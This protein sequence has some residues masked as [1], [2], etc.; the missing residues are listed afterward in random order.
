MV[1][2]SSST[3]SQTT[4]MYLPVAVHPKVEGRPVESLGTVRFFKLLTTSQNFVLRDP[5][6]DNDVDI[7]AIRVVFQVPYDQRLEWNSQEALQLLSIQRRSELDL[8]YNESGRRGKP[9]RTN[10][11]SPQKNRRSRSSKPR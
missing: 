10:S 7:V 6:F 8:Y 1:R 2:G 5:V 9:K 3:C 4:T 11:R